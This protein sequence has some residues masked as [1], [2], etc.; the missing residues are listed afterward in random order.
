MESVLKGWPLELGNR[1]FHL[2]P[3]WKPFGFSAAF[4]ALWMSVAWN[5]MR[6]PE[7]TPAMR[8]REVALRL[9]CFACHGPDGEGGVSSPGASGAAMPGWD[10]ATAEMYIHGEQDIREWILLGAPRSD[11]AFRGPSDSAY[12]GP[13]PMPA[14]QG[15]L[16][17]GELDD[18]VAYFLAV[19]GWA[20]DMPDEA[21]AGRAVAAR[22]GC[23]GCHG[24]SGMGGMPNPGSFK[25]HIPPWDG[26]EFADLARDDG[27]LREW[28]LEGRVRRLWSN[29][30][31]R[32][33]LEGQTVRMPAYRA[34][35]S[36]EEEKN[37][38]AYVRWLRDR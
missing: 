38:V 4:L 29:P 31:A 32:R 7:I 19:S 27:E 16:D 9:G 20:P 24:P 8:G 35:V 25:G 21:F 13:L 36:A 3:R 30:F 18:L 1:L 11:S 26:D 33:Y 6:R 23:F 5:W 12:R 15:L 28:I 34:H 10:N 37:M 14:Y 22:L 2:A 17:K